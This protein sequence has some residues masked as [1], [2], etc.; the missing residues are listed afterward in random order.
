M[1]SSDVLFHGILFLCVAI[2]F[3]LTSCALYRQLAILK[4][5]MNRIDASKPEWKLFYQL[6]ASKVYMM[7]RVLA[8]CAFI[9]AA[10]ALFL[11]FCGLFPF[12]C[13][14]LL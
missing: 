6:R 11:I 13:G 7:I 5:G 12:K 10:G 4:E 9:I 14:G 1:C 2:F 3:G 8:V